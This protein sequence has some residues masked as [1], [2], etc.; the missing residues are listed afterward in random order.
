MT[1]NK[2]ESTKS[3]IAHVHPLDPPWPHLTPSPRTHHI[4]HWENL[5][6]TKSKKIHLDSRSAFYDYLHRCPCM[7]VFPYMHAEKLVSWKCLSLPS[8]IR[9]V[10]YKRTLK[11]WWF[12]ADLCTKLN[13]TCEFFWT[14]FKYNL[15]FKCWPL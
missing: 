9:G 11:I 6:P 14:P 8:I 12:L 5:C 4:L 15:F 3:E 1:R 2:E 13:L 10:L 7:H